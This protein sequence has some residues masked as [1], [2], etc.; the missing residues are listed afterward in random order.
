[1]GKKG[2]ILGM[3]SVYLQSRHGN[4]LFMKHEQR[5]L[6][7]RIVLSYQIVFDVCLC[8]TGFGVG[9][10]RNSQKWAIVPA[11]GVIAKSLLESDPLNMNLLS[12]PRISVVNPRETE[13]L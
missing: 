2:G 6:N 1:V 11:I 5:M 12:P 9:I 3:I 4:I 13:L 10:G 7:R 8:V